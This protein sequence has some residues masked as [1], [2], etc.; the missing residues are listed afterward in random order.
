MRR[1][2]ALAVLAALVAVG[3]GGC[4]EREQTALYQDGKYRGKPDIRPWDNAAPADGS[5][6]WVKGDRESWENQIRD[7]HNSQSE[8]RRMGH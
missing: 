3:A 8:Y 7:R 1:V 5:A 2:T 6:S 4:G